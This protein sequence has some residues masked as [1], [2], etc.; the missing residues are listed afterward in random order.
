MRKEECY[1]LGY[2]SKTHAL[3]GE[4][5]VIL[6]VD[7]PDDYIDL[8]SVFIE[9]KGDLVPYF[10]ESSFFNNDK[11]IL[12]LEDIDT[13]EDAAK[14][15]SKV[16]YLPLSVLPK[17]EDNQFYFHEVIGYSVEDELKGE[18]GNVG[19]VYKPSSQAIM[20]LIHKGKEIMI[21]MTEE[22][23]QSVNHDQKTMKVKLPDGLIELYLEA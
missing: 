8:E 3:D 7:Y 15:K 18:L 19:D 20:T 23:I 22:I 4:I 11:F 2:V 16:L 10:V 12:K 13:V 1:E 5:A 14:L 17:L 21:P 6:D 9:M